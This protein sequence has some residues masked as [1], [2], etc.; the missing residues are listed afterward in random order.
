MKAMVVCT[1]QPSFSLTITGEMSKWD[2]DTPG[3]TNLA[4]ADAVRL[5]RHPLSAP[6]VT[7]SK[8]MCYNVRAWMMV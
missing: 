1:P 8:V 3:S 5:L 4:V 6:I 7:A 2:H